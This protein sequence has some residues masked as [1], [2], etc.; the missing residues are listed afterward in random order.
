MGTLHAKSVSVGVDSEEDNLVKFNKSPVHVQRVTVDGLTRTKD[1]VVAEEIKKLLAAKTFD[2]LVQLSHDAKVKMQALGLFENVVI[3]I[4]VSKDGKE[5]GY[6]VLFQ[7]QEFR[8]VG[9]GVQTAFGEN[10]VCVDFQIKMP[11]MLGRGEQLSLVYRLGTRDSQYGAFYQKPLNNDPNFVFGCTAYKFNGQFPWSGYRETDKG[12]AVSLDFRTSLG[13]HRLQWE[14]VLRDLRALSINTSFAVREQS[15]YSL[16]SSIKHTFSIDSRDDVVLPSVGTL[17]Q[18]CQEYAGLGGNVEYAKQDG[19]FQWNVS[20]APDAVFQVSLAGGIMTSLGTDISIC[21]KFF[22]GGPLTL[23]GFDLKSIGPCSEADALGAES[24]WLSAAHIYCPLPFGWY[25]DHFKTHL[26]INA[27]NLGNMSL[28]HPFSSIYQ[29]ASTFR[30]SYGF[31]I[32]WHV[33]GAVRL[34]LNYV[35]PKRLQN[36]DKACPGLQFGIGIKFL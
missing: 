31:G 2:E 9:C 33:S 34:E 3:A 26:F 28:W 29:M 30:W 10:E 14:S 4:D 12:T 18:I 27:G 1:D 11:N 20:L 8:C 32:V 6:E 13:S 25:G 23:R 15:G 5:N 17:W 35:I 7:V 24:Y 19:T 22:L 36:G 21:D 16:K